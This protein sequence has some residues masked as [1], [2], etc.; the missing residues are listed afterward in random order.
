[1]LQTCGFKIVEQTELKN[2]RMVRLVAEKPA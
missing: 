1:M 2:G